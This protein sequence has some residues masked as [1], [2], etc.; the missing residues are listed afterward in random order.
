MKAAWIVL[1]L[2]LVVAGCGD[3]ADPERA[4]AG[5][6]NPPGT[7]LGWR[8][9]VDDRRGFRFA[10]PPGWH[11][12]GQS[13]TPTMGDPVEIL[14]VATFALEESRGLC[15]SLTDIPP[16]QALVTLQERGIGAHGGPS[17]PPRPATFEPDPSL[18]GSS[19][20]PYCISGDQGRPIPM[21]D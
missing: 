12:A 2:V 13:L 11:L 21:L 20:W 18:P 9:H 4:S 6:E 8:E 17:F 16:D 15:R 3:E 14:L 19:T 10:L 1:V 5:D 7:P